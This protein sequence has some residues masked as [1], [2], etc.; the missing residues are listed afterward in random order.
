MRTVGRICLALCSLRVLGA[1]PIPIRGIRNVVVA[2]ALLRQSPATQG[3]VFRAARAIIPVD[4]IFVDRK[5]A[6]G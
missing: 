6:A 3:V 4:D 1:T 5:R 2:R